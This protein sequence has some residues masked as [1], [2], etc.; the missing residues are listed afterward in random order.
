MCSNRLRG[1]YKETKVDETQE[2]RCRWLP[3]HGPYGFDRGSFAG[4]QQGC[5]HL[6]EP[7]DFTKVSILVNNHQ[8]VVRLTAPLYVQAA[9]AA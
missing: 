8:R 9:Y 2:S 6:S 3:M 1:D 7:L 5:H 4:V